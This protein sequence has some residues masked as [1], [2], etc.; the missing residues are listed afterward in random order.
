[1]SRP[2]G[3]PQFDTKVPHR[4]TSAQIQ[5]N[6]RPA[7]KKIF[8]AILPFFFGLTVSQ[9]QETTRIPRLGIL[10]PE[11]GRAES[12]A[13]KGLRDGLKELG[14]QEGKNLQI[15]IRDAKGNRGALKREAGELVRQKVLLIFTT[16]TRATQAARA[17]TSDIPIVF[18]HPADPV[19]LGLV[20]SMARPGANVTGVAALFLQMSDRRMEI[21]KQLAPKAGRVIIF[22]DS[23]NPYSRENF[24]A[25]KK[26][27][28][29]L[30]LKVEERPVKSIEELKKSI[31][32]MQSREDE[33]LFHVPDDLIESQADFIFEAARQKG[34][35]TMFSEESWVT[36]GGLAGY[37]P[38]YYQMGRQAARM[39]AKIL[40]GA[41]PQDLPIE[42]AGKFDLVINLRTANAI[43]LSI[44]P[45]V[46]KKADRV[47]R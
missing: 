3:L 23:N 47:I 9:A 2:E 30:G 27:G 6:K 44:P 10:V 12:Q 11:S 34:W 45:E 35:P 26:A 43:G 29:K 14:Y 31:N 16:G 8:F 17:A 7:M 21:L 39:A 33:A 42:K 32:A 24:L 18:T 28:E 22:Y 5:E 37:G 13:I 36:Q 41:K 46:L 15:E 4:I 20:K 40:K 1:M 38:N 25:A 19:A